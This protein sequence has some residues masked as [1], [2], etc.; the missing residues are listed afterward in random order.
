MIKHIV[1][2]KF[3]DENKSKFMKEV[4]KDLE[5]L[6]SQIPELISMEVGLNIIKDEQMPDLVLYST[7]ENEKGLN[8]YRDHPAHVVV[9]EK[10]KPMALKRTVVD[11]LV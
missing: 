9:V 11:Y 8:I 7:F 3:K 1:A 10:I 6:V 4:K 5:N 2:F